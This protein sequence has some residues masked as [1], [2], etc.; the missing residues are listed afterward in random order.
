MSV[1][2]DT[3]QEPV[4]EVVAPV[5][6]VVDREVALASVGRTSGPLRVGLVWDY[7]GRGDVVF[8]ALTKVLGERLPDAEVVGWDRFGN[9]HGAEERR[10]M[11]E[12]PG[13]LRENEVDMAV[14]GV[15]S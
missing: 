12:L 9:I 13:K 11:G 4:Y 3:P 8:G 2:H 1:P 10:V 15:G 6:S 5:G 14:I 7:V